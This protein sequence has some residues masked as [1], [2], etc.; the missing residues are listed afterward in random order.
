MLH[1]VKIYVMIIR[2][3]RGGEVW[4]MNKSKL[5]AAMAA[6]ASLS[7]KDA[8]AALNAFTD[9]VADAP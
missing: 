7:K 8:E 3:N 1:F 6:K 4:K 2:K 9:T 5:V